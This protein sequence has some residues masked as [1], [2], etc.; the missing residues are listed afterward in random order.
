MEQLP[1]GPRTVEGTWIRHVPHGT[2]LLGR[3]DTPSD[4]RWQRGDVVRP[5]Y[6]A[7]TVATATAEWY[8]SLAEWGLSPQDHIPYDHHRW[9]L[10]LELADLSDIEQLRRVSLETPRP[11]RSRWP[12]YQRIGEQLWREGWAGLI[13]PSAA[14]PGSLI[15]CVFA[16]CSKKGG[17]ATRDCHP[18]VSGPESLEHGQLRRT[19]LSSG[20]RPAKRRNCSFGTSRSMLAVC[21]RGRLRAGAAASDLALE[22]DGTQAIGSTDDFGQSARSMRD[23]PR[24]S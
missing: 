12:T 11:S 24:V 14:Y 4:G 18:F 5:L 7:D 23:N 13:A 21:R 10:H 20:G 16:T 8:R 15:T 1:V 17:P 2:D 19:G 6:L 22:A 3:P 9:R